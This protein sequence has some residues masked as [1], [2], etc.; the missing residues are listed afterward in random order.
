M[1][2]LS[3]FDNNIAV[4]AVFT[5]RVVSTAVARYNFAAR[6]M[7]E[8]SLREGDIVRI[9]SKIGGDQGWWKGEANGRVSEPWKC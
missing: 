3:V 7:R 1:Y 4:L 9:Y 2:E 6:D 5:P 8:L